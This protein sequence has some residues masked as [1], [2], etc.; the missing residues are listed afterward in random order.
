MKRHLVVFVKAPRFGAVKTR[1]A[2][3]VGGLA[4]WRFYRDT[5]AQLLRRLGRDRR[6][7]CWL[8]VTPDRFA[9][10][11]RFWPPW[12]PRLAQGAGDLGARMA[13]QLRRLPPGPV[14]IVGSDVPDLGADHVARA[15][16]ALGRCDAVFGP[17]PDGGYWL[18]GVRRRPLPRGIFRH[19]R[20]STRHALADTLAGLGPGLK[21]AFLEQLADIDDGAALARW[22]RAQGRS[23]GVTPAYR[24][25]P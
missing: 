10:Y 20:W 1:L 2:A 25:V 15:F 19:V 9:R 6:W 8:A 24:R 5:T 21:P 11:G 3:E 18:I 16:R 23:G 4:A 12:L 13:R 14:V 17:A 22:R 7:T